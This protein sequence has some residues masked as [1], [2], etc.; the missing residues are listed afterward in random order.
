MIPKPAT[1]RQAALA[2]W[3]SEFAQARDRRWSDPIDDLGGEDAAAVPRGR[4]DNG[5][6]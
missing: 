1:V 6:A 5:R 3:P 4:S 2:S